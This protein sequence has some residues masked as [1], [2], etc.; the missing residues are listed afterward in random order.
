MLDRERG[1]QCT[2]EASSGGTRDAL[3][4]HSRRYVPGS[5]VLETTLAAGPSPYAARLTITDFMPIRSGVDGDKKAPSPAARS[6]W[7]VA[8]G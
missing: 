2:V 6:G 3:Q 5:N 7:R 1:G 8:A 4:A